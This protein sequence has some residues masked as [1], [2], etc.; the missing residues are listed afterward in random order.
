MVVKSATKKKLI[1]LG[2]PE[3]FAH[4]LANDRKWDE[5]KVLSAQDIAQ[6]CETDSDQAAKILAQIE[7]ASRKSSDGDSDGGG[8]TTKITLRKSRS[9]RVKA[10]VDLQGYDEGRKMQSLRSEFADEPVY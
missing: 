6:V 8:P 4:A 7:G 10:D 5:V 9:R 3:N 2:V 1:D